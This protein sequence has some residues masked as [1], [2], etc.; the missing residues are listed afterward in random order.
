MLIQGLYL[1]L[2]LPFLEVL[3]YFLKYCYKIA[4]LPLSCVCVCFERVCMPQHMCG[5]Q[6][7]TFG[8]LVS[9]TTKWL[10]DL[11]QVIGLWRQKPLPDHPP[12][13]PELAFLDICFNS[14]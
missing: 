8:R 6:K 1:H 12:Y 9:L 11:T 5:A 7:T 3:K 13:C 2:V 10:R 4:P 14:L